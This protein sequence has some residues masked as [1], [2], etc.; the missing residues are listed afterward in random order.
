MTVTAK[1]KVSEDHSMAGE[2]AVSQRNPISS[3]C[4]GGHLLKWLPGGAHIGIGKVP[5]AVGATLP[6]QK[7]QSCSHAGHNVRTAHGGLECR[8]DLRG[9]TYLLFQQLLCLAPSDIL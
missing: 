8:T 2:D 3:P 7:S 6:S 5:G 1:L 4:T 9:N